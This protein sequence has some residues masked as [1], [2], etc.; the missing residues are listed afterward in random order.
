MNRIIASLVSGL[1]FRFRGNNINIRIISL[2][3][4]ELCQV[5]NILGGTAHTFL[6]SL[7]SVSPAKLF[8]SFSLEEQGMHQP[9][10]FY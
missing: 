7:F 8:S 2:L 10:Y 1:V 6:F 5:G 4:S 3:Q 9:L